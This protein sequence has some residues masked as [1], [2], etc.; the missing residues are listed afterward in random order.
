MDVEETKNEQEI[1]FNY[2]QSQKSNSSEPG[3]SLPNNDLANLL[4]P[5]GST[6]ATSQA[7]GA[8]TEDD[9]EG[10]CQ[11]CGISSP[12]FINADK[13]DL[14]YVLQCLMLTNC[15]GCT[16]IIEVSSYNEHKLLQCSKKADFK[17]CPRCK[18]AVEADFYEQHVTSLKCVP[19]DAQMVR[20]PLC[21]RDLPVEESEEKTWKQHL[22]VE[23]CPGANVR[24]S[25]NAKA[26]VSILR[27]KQPPASEVIMEEDDE[28]DDNET[29]GGKT[30]LMRGTTDNQ[31]GLSKVHD[32]GD[33]E[34]EEGGTIDGDNDEVQSKIEER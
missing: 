5:D 29:I 19:S 9:N 26:R 23:K 6:E 7:L 12:E 16:Q 28:E 13:M 32:E 30:P 24:I 15:A 8:G 4:N 33:L 31:D 2:A 20:C 11:F 25:T 34:D 27:A 18:M 10:T 3:Q 1:D 14:H 22:A 17:S 21:Q